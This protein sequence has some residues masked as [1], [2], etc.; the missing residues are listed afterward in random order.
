MLETFTIATFAGQEGTTF[1][2]ALA[3]GV[4]LEATLLQV[5][6]LSAKGPSGEELPRKRV[7]FSLQFRV[8]SPDRFEQKTYT[9]EHAVIGKFALFLVPIGREGDGYRCEAIFT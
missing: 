6:S 9:V 2:L 8:A 5:T 4:A 3:S 7:P 1:R